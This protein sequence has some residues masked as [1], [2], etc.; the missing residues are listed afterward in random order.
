MKKSTRLLLWISV[1]GFV[2]F[3]ASV[4]VLVLVVSGDRLRPSGEPRTL[5]VELGPSLGDAPQEGAFVMNPQDFP[6]LLTEVTGAIRRAADDPDV[7]GLLLIID[8]IGLGFGGVQEL[9]A[10]LEAFRASDKPCVAHADEYGNKEYLLAA[11]CGR[12]EVSPAGIVLVNGLQVT[13]TYYKNTLD[14]IGVDPELE[15][16]GDFKSAVE[17]FERTEPSEAAR[18]ATD[19]L[20]DSLYGQFVGALARTRGFEVDRV[21]SLLDD[22]PLAPDLA[23]QSGWVDAVEFESQAREAAGDDDALDFDD[24]VEATRRTWRKSPKVAV[25]HADGSIISGSSGS[26]ILGG[27]FVGDEDLVDL[28]DEVE[29]DDDVVAVVLRV[30]SPGGSGLASDNIWR[31]LEELRQEKPVVVSMSDLAASGGYYIAVG[32]DHIVAE[33]GTLTGSIGVFGGKMNVSG[34]YEKLGL[35]RTVYKRGEMADL[36]SSASAFSDAGRARFREYLD[37]FYSLFL[38]RVSEGRK[39]AVE[40][41]HAVAKGRVWTGEQALERGLVDELGGLD[42]AIARAR[43]LAQVEGETGILRLPVQKTLAQ[44]I[45]EQLTDPDARSSRAALAL[46]PVA[47]DGLALAETLARVLDGVGVAA[48]LPGTLEVR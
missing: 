34:L 25:I 24:Y 47:G 29:E 1:L 41:V 42:V 44:Q 21:R 13:E 16:V 3:A 33:P 6:P 36:L 22:P 15:H 5:V 46:L 43:E 30:N 14:R 37:T 17:P 39:L 12:V 4:A 23:L 32:S 26:G 9:A 10:A 40:D 2:L 19:A 48:M 31:A 7:A 8:P 18:M 28:L 45:V 20:L 35:T 11:A 27:R 38:A